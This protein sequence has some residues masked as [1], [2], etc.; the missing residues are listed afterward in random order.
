[1]IIYLRKEY[2]LNMANTTVTGWLNN[3]NTGERIKQECTEIEQVLDYQKKC[4][5]DGDI[6]GFMEGYWNSEE[7]VFTS[8]HH[9]PAYGWKA[10]LN[11]YRESY[12]NKERMGTFNY[13]I[14]ECKLLNDT[15]AQLNGTWELKR[16]YDHP[17]GDFY[18]TFRKLKDNWLII[19]DS[20]ISY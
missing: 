10:T 14:L 9:K 5:N 12:P 7:L 6:D 13:V 8:L 3:L 15:I 18:L 2:H 19:K 4:W 20:T 1:M 11:R 17:K 16:S